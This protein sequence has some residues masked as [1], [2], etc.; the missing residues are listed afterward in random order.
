MCL[1]KV[2]LR[3]LH[4]YLNRDFERLLR[5]PLFKKDLFV[6]WWLDWI[7]IMFFHCSFF[8]LEELTLTP[9]FSVN[10]KLGPCR[11]STTAWKQ[12][13]FKKIIQKYPYWSTIAMTLKI[14]SCYQQN[15]VNFRTKYKILPKIRSNWA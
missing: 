9:P 13:I 6:L 5:L 3:K 12:N 14:H 15:M 1:I 11:E 2:G 7:L 10:C 8:F 4:N